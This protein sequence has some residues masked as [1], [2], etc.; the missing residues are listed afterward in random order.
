MKKFLNL[1]LVSTAVLAAVACQK[2][3]Q[4]NDA[5][6]VGVK[7]V[8]TQFVLNVAA[9]PTTKQSADVVQM[10]N[11][12][13]GMENVKLFC[14]NTGLSVAD[15]SVAPYVLTTAAP[16]AGKVKEFELGT[17]MTDSYLDNGDKDENG[18]NDNLQNSSNRVLQLSIPVGVDAILLYGKARKP[19]SGTDF[20]YGCTYD[21][22]FRDP[23]KECTISSTP[24]ETQ[25][26]AHPILDDNTTPKYDATAGAMI[27]VINEILNTSVDASASSTFD[28]DGLNVTFTDLPAISWADYGHRY[29]YDK[30]GDESR[31]GASDSSLDHPVTNL[32]EVLGQC[33]YLFTYI[34]PSDYSGNPGDD[35]WVT[36]ITG[37]T[38]PTRPLGEYR[39]GSS[40]AV[41]RMIID[42]YKIIKAASEAVPTTAYEANAARLASLILSKAGQY[43]ST[44]TGD[45]NSVDIIKTYLTTASRW[46]GAWDGNVTNLNNYPGQFHVPE[47]AAQLGFYKKGD[48]RDQ[49]DGGGTAPQDEFYYYHPNHPLVN[50]TMTE[51]EPRKYLYPAELWYY[52]NSPIRTTSTDVA[53]ADY[54]NGVNNWKADASW[55]SGNWAANSAVASDTRGVAVTNSINYGVALL[56]SVVTTGS[57]TTLQDNRAAL[58]DETT[59]KEIS[60]SDSNI[61]LTGILVGGVN[62]RMNWQFT[63]FYTANNTP[64]AESNLSLFDGVIYD[65]ETGDPLIKNTITNYTLVYDNYNSTGASGNGA[66]ADQN[67]V[68]ISLE[69]KNDGDPFWGRDNLIPTGGT[70]YLVGKLSKPDSDQVNGLASVWPTDHQIPPVW[71]V[72]GEAVTAT[73]VKGESKKIARVFMQDFTTVVTFNI[74][75]TS[76]QKAYYSVPDLRASQMSLGLSVDLQWI[77]GLNYSVNL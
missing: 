47:G 69:F 70:F 33:Y 9:A 76:L 38:P 75:A 63:R 2:E 39:A 65:S 51:F 54:P 29:E 71:G 15:G 48:A 50:P 28:P 1:V 58:T 20:V 4:V 67:D 35:G 17:L 64:S 30:M 25:F 3:Q 27:A 68:Y 16:A 24:A 36:A 44:E 6:E 42:M 57:V 34:K 18:T 46:K 19:E 45:Y 14:Y 23:Q 8:T 13:R 49:K 22:D 26:Y 40:F 66:Q 43:F 61:K 56:K 74:G 53:V 31:Y 10:N 21:Y 72:N 77:N 73:A 32:E 62:P 5:P 7:E 12:F 60:V 52:V 37:A 59:N 41:K 55:T 11:N